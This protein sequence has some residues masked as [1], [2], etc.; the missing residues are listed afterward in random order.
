MS[1]HTSGYY[2]QQWRIPPYMLAGLIRYVE[3]GQP[4]GGF[5][6]AVLEN[7]FV[8]AA[9]R[10][11]DHNLANLAAYAAWLH[12]EAP[13]GAWGSPAKV[14]AWLKQKEQE[15]KHLAETE[16]TQSADKR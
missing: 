15:R 6:R 4:P 10:A 13:L 12:N 9:G 16:V 14:A 3:D 7:N 1:D 8:E 11:D 5:L 2:F